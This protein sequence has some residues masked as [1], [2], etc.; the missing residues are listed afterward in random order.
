MWAIVAKAFRYSEE[1]SPNID[2]GESLYDFFVREVAAMIPET[3]KDYE[4]ERKLV[5]QTAQ[6][7]G[8]FI[9]SPIEQQSLRFFW[10][11]ECI[12]GG[13]WSLS[14]SRGLPWL[15]LDRQPLCCELVPK[16]PRAGRQATEGRGLD[17][18]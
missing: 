17:P 6:Q 2:P 9:G 11:E 15:T 8:A 5:M 7:W 16:D 12:E 1:N 18:L 13:A 3:E 10:L 14:E 4:R